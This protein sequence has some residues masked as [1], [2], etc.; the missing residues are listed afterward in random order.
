MG[1]KRVHPHAFG[2]RSIIVGSLATY[3]GIKEHTA[4]E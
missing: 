4:V 3:G 2:Y 1:D